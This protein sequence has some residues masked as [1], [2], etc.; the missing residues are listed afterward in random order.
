MTKNL[1]VCTWNLCLG[2]SSKKNI[3]KNTVLL[4]KIDVCCLQEVEI[5][6]NYPNDLLTFRGYNIEVEQNDEKA[7]VAIYISTNVSYSRRED[8]E[9]M[10]NNLLIIDIHGPKTVRIINIYRSFK[11]LNNVNQRIKF[12]TQLNVIKNSMTK[13]TIVLGDFNL[14]DSKRYNIDYPYKNL[15][16]DF[17]ETLSD[18]GLIQLVK[19]TTWSRLVNHT[20]KSSILDHIYTSDS[21]TVDS[22]TSFS[23][24]FGDHLMVNFNLNLKS[25]PPTE[26]TKR[27]WTHYSKT[28]LC[29]E[30]S[31]VDWDLGINDVQQYWNV[32]ENLLV[33]IVDKVAPLATFTNN[34]ITNI[35]LP[36]SI[37]NILNKRHRFLKNFKRNP[38]KELK[39]KITELDLLVRIYFVNNKRKDVRRGILP[40]NSKTLWNVVHIAKDTN[41]QTLPNKMFLDSNE[42]PSLERADAFAKFFD[43]K[44]TSNKTNVNVNVYNGKRK[45]I[46]N[47]V[48]FMDPESITECIKTI[49]IKN[50]EGH[51]R[52]P[53][54]I[55]VDG[56]AYLVRPLTVLFEMI[57]RYNQLPDQWLVAKVFPVFKKGNKNK[58]ENYRPISNLY[59]TSKIFEKLILRQ[60]L[61]IQENSKIDFTGNEQHGFK[62]AKSTSTAGLIIQSI[63]SR[64]VD[65]N[66]YA[67]MAS[68]DLTAAFDLV[69]TRLLL[70][71][72]KIISLPPI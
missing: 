67:L 47:E 69:D 29:N 53:Q 62:K 22:V 60:I 65:T 54:R 23:P 5:Q 39:A 61:L 30:L 70:K 17:D 44:V 59:S 66:H 68:I 34:K 35:D 31:A 6:P 24:N 33:N 26:I 3:V 45:A 56:S 38:S 71:R 51:D 4:N 41:I 10:N 36:N 18:F 52:I 16:L 46:S 37:K 58:I 15:F 12:Q 11:P 42:I 72:L 55:L 14:D 63:I 25:L 21:T 32:F 50:C 20:L 1:K 13:N 43:T 9:G 49:K 40:G 19:F 57:Y 28:A 7:R 48:M 8:L 27:N 64:A 2:L